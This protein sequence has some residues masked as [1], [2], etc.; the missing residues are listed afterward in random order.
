MFTKQLNYSISILLQYSLPHLFQTSNTRHRNTFQP[1]LH[2]PGGT[3]S[4]LD[5]LEP[6][7][8]N[9]DNHS[10]NISKC[11]PRSIYTITRITRV[12]VWDQLLSIDAHT[13]TEE[14]VE[15]VVD[16]MEDISVSL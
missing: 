8:A 13:S 14:E 10:A 2:A 16:A 11:I 15:S 4:L 3:N 1:S 5:S 12:R 6:N 9:I 7:Y